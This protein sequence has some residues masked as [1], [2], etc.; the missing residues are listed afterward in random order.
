MYFDVCTFAL[1]VLCR[2][3]VETK[4]NTKKLHMDRQE[5]DKSKHT[6]FGFCKIR[7]PYLLGS[8]L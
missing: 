8:F 3:P 1:E 6:Y 4:G 5:V 2:N 7:A